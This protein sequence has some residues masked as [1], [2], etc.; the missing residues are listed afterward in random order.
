MDEP[1]LRSL[2]SSLDQHL[3]TLGGWL[4]F[5]TVMVIVGCAGELIFVVYAYLDDRRVWFHA[6]STGSVAPPEKP[7]ILVLILEVL[8]V[9]LVVVG[10]AGELYIDWQ[11]GDLQTQLRDANGKLILLLEQEAGDAKK[12]ALGAADALKIAQQRLGVLEINSDAL[13]LRIQNASGK[14]TTV[15]DAVRMQGPRWRLLEDGKKTFVSSLKPFAGQSFTIINCGTGNTEQDVLDQYILR[16]MGKDGANWIYSGFSSQ[17]GC[18]SVFGVGGI[19]IEFDIKGAKELK[20]AG[21]AL[22]HTFNEIKISA[23]AMPVLIEPLDLARIPPEFR[24]IYEGSSIE[25]LA[26]NPRTVVVF[27]GSNPM[28]DFSK[29]FPELTKHP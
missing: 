3:A 24:S 6:R 2:I 15:E 18:T 19:L 25:A 22:T 11:S 20:D 4:Y 14:L 12:S 23:A 9:A 29:R 8:S 26:K 5:W 17:S 21:Y 13:S 16:F 7:S 1:A 27:V 28:I 10:I